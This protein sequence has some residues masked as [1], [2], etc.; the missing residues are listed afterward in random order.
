MSESQRSTR[1]ERGVS[2]DL[3]ELGN[4]LASL[5]SSTEAVNRLLA[6]FSKQLERQGIAVV[7]YSGRLDTLEKLTENL[8]RAIRSA[9][10][11]QT[12]LALIESGLRDH[13]QDCERRRQR[14]ENEKRDDNTA[15]RQWATVIISAL[16]SSASLIVT[17]WKLNQ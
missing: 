11:F 5:N 17:I 13:E 4:Q 7:N 10:G 9:D 6:G 12:R 3:A 8:D 2:R 14:S 15:T 1:D 16:L